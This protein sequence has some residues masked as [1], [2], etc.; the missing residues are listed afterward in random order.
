M[1]TAAQLDVACVRS[2]V[3]G[4]WHEVVQLEMEEKRRQAPRVHFHETTDQGRR[5]LPLAQRKPRYFG[6]EFF[7]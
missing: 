7:V 2:T 5:R 1:R 3:G 4:E 6:R